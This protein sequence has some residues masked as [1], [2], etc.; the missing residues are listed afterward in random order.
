[1][2]FFIEPLRAFKDN[3]IW[4]MVLSENKS[5]WIVDP[6]DAIPVIDFIEKNDLCLKGIL[7]THHHYDHCDGLATLREKYNVVA[8]GPEHESISATNIVKE[9]DNI[10][11]P[12]FNFSLKVLAVP[13]HTLDHIVY[14]CESENFVFCGDTLF[15]A[16]CGKVFEGT[17]EQM[18]HSLM[19]LENLPGAAKVYCGHEYT[20]SNLKF[21]KHVDSNNRRIDQY[22]AWV[23]KQLDNNKPTLPSTIFLEK[24]VNPFLRTTNPSIIKFLETKLG[25][26][27]DNPV[28]VFSELRVLKN[29]FNIV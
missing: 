8:Y 2:S 1:M 11:L 22:T 17:F 6:G 7:I 12:D 23:M 16:G 25:K 28:Q 15:S 29:N 13:G 27:L 26:Q 21:A 14:Y 9:G 20:L 19:K 10:F 18:Y 4:A 3:Y 24:E 5:V